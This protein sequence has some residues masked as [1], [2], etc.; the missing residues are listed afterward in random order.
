MCLQF[1]LL[2]SQPIDH[3]IEHHCV[4]GS[5]ALVDIEHSFDLGLDGSNLIQPSLLHTDV[6]AIDFSAHVQ[7]SFSN[8]SGNCDIEEALVLGWLHCWE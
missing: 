1:C 7:T 4:H 2:F 3:H 8:A 5:E 6:G